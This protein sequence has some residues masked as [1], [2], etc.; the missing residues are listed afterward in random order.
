VNN[1]FPIYACSFRT[2]LSVKITPY[3]YI[4]Q[5]GLEKV[6]L[7]LKWS[8]YAQKKPYPDHIIRFIKKGIL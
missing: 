3:K 4:K 2:A 8:G 1:N 6:N 5:M 7:K